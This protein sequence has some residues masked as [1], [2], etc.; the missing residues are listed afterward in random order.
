MVLLGS[1]STAFYQSKDWNKT[2]KL[3]MT[4]KRGTV[5]L[6]TFSFE[7]IAVLLKFSAVH[8]KFRQCA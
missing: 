4:Y 3:K 1:K 5:K 8:P 2:N 7:N 6:F